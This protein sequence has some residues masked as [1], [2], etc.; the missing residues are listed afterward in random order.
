L[1]SVVAPR[2][3]APGEAA[4]RPGVQTARPQWREERAGIALR[5]RRSR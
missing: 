4:A 3:A 5:D 2:L 1:K